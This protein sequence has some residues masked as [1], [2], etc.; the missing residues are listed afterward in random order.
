MKMTFIVS[1]DAHTVRFVQW[2][3]RRKVKDAREEWKT[4]QAWLGL[5]NEDIF[6][7]HLVGAVDGHIEWLPQSDD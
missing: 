1:D 2:V 6:E 4:A 3:S 5:S 7:M